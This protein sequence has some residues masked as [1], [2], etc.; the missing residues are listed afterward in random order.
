MIFAINN[1][2]MFTDFAENDDTNSIK[3]RSFKNVRKTIE[4]VKEA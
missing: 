2:D 3:F 4:I 1:V